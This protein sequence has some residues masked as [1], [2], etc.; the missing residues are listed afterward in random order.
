MKQSI[1][2]NEKYGRPALIGLSILLW[3]LIINLMDIFGYEETWWLWR[4]PTEMP[5]FMDFRLIPGSA[6]SFLRGFEPSVENPFDPRQR[7]FNYPTFWRIFFYSGVTQDD[8]IWI[9]ILMLVLFF[10]AV[11]LFPDKLTAAD[12]L[13]MLVV[14]FS[15]ASML[16]YE[17][18]N[19]D[20][21]VFFICVM[22]I[23]LASYS[24]YLGAAGIL[25]GAVIKIFPF[26]GI[27]ILLKESRDRFLWLSGI[28]ALLF[29]AYFF[30]TFETATIAW[31]RTMRGTEISYGANVLFD[32]Y[33]VSTVR[34]LSERLS[35]PK[36]FVQYGSI[37]VAL[38]LIVLAG[39][40]VLARQ[41]TLTASSERNLA[42]FRM[43]AS[44]YVGTFLL[45]NNWDYRLA[46]LV[47]VVP[48]LMEWIRS[49]QGKIRSTAKLCMLSLLLSCWHFL[50]WYAPTVRSNPLLVEL[51]YLIDELMNW[52][53]MVTLAYLF[54]GS[55]PDWITAGLKRLIPRRRLVPSP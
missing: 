45:G 39:T 20:L 34:F 49:P 30:V 8:T 24:P 27:S 52:T 50:A 51:T 33:E 17:R 13:A 16:L 15:P 9:G 31:N 25:F 14:L 32:R 18:G 46:F 38:L 28:C 19:V 12:S 43:G 53:L 11:F 42:A 21:I 5:P 55:L 10:V 44:I 48:Q 3:L 1:S 36:P 23:V 40:S 37:V 47:L 41:Q 35:D 6:E 22:N 29:L 26:F 4:V 54:V 2:Q 7:I